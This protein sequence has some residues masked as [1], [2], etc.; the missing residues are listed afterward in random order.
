MGSGVEMCAGEKGRVSAFSII[1]K[2][3][4]NIALL[5]VNDG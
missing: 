2:Y 1:C 5:M 4:I 3:Y